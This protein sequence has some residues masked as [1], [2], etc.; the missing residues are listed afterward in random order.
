LPL[1]TVSVGAQNLHHVCEVV[2]AGRIIRGDL[3]DVLPQQ[4]GAETVDTG[5]DFAN[6]SLFEGRSLELD[7]AQH[8]SFGPADDT[9]VRGGIVENGGQHGGRRIARGL[10]RDQPF[11]GFAREK[12]NVS[13]EH[14]KEPLRRRTILRAEKR[15]TGALRHGLQRGLHS[16]GP[17]RRRH[18][19]RLMADHGDYAL[20]RRDGQRRTSHMFHQS[21]PAGA[22]QHLGGV[23]FHTRAETGRQNHYRYVDHFFY[24]GAL[25][26]AA[27]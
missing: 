11:H 24:S 20:R 8:I 12:R 10:L 7:N 14:D 6:G 2:L 17:Q 21:Q 5:V 4:A 27:I 18:S 1:H 19:L 15:L 22:M 3:A 13:I 23:R 26:L 9:P 25:A 16:V